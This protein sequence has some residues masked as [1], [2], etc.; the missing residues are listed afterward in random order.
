MGLMIEGVSFLAVLVGCMAYNEGN[1][2]IIF[3]KIY[4]KI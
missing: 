3:V 1:S 4:L 2:K